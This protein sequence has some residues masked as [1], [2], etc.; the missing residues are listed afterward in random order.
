MTFTVDNTLPTWRKVALASWRPSDD[1]AITGWLEI[2][3][4]SL[5]DYLPAVREATGAHVTITH[6]VGK[7]AALAFAENPACNAV[8]SFGRLKRRASV[9]VFFSVAAGSELSG[10][11]L[12]GVDE[13]DLA[14]IARR[15]S[16]DV[17]RIRGA[18]DTPLQRSQGLLKRLP[19]VLLKPVMRMSAF[20]MFDLG[21]DLSELGVPLDPFGSVIVSNVGVFGIAHGFAPLIPSGRTAAILTVGSI[22]KRA[23]VVQNKI[24][25][26]PMLTI[27]GTFD[28]RVVDG[29][30]L[31]RIQNVLR[32]VLEDP[33]H[34]LGTPRVISRVCSSGTSRSAS[35]ASAS[36]PTPR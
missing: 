9:D 24:E 6:L 16:V 29:H 18:G 5:T 21:L 15:L 28:H 23:V 10:A 30:H 19:G 22:E 31:G 27:C 3:A 17:Q 1:P 13:M 8:V 11:K 7:A 33:F 25:A 12:E 14:D 36:P 32:T 35:E 26:R 2:D 34:H 20:A 4:T